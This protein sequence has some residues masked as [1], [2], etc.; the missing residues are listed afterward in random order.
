M[1]LSPD[2]RRA[3]AQLAA[4]RR[5]RGADATLTDNAARLEKAALDRR[6]DQLLAAAPRLTAEQ[7]DRLAALRPSGGDAS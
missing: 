2:E 3:R 6:I 5:W 1:P 7:A 4:L